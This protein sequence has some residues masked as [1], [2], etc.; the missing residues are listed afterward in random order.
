MH[1][2]ARLLAVCG[3]ALLSGAASAQGYPPPASAPTQEPALGVS[4]RQQVMKNSAVFMNNG[5]PAIFAAYPPNVWHRVDLKPW[6][7]PATSPWAFLAGILIITHN[8]DASQI[9]N[10]MIGLR[11]VGDTETG[12]CDTTGRYVGQVAAVA[13]AGGARST[14]SSFVPLIDGAFEVCWSPNPHV[15][16]YPSVPGVGVNLHL[17]AW[18]AL[19]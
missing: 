8:G 4:V 6:G 14:M 12:N 16:L 10:L 3:L 13:A 2:I 1:F 19:P 5:D 9:A 15:G 7:V 11:R 17:Q 18:G